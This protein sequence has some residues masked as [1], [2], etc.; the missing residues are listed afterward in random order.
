[1]KKKISRTVPFELEY[2]LHLLESADCFNFDDFPDVR[3]S[4][5]RLREVVLSRIMS[6]FPD[7]D[8]ETILSET[9]SCSV[10]FS[11]ELAEYSK[12]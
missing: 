9:V 8:E 12:K 4:Y 3:N 10:S 1:M 11:V 2:L 6:Y 5:Y 7:I